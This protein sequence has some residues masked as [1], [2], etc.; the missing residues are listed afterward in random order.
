MFYTWRVRNIT[1]SNIHTGI[2]SVLADA[3]AEERGEH[4]EVAAAARMRA[5]AFNTYPAPPA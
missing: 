3:W 1:V 5:A 2:L 4:S